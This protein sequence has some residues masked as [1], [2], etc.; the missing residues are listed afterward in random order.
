MN[1]STNVLPPFLKANDKL[2]LF[3]GVC[4][5]CNAWSR[6]II[7]FDTDRVFILASVQSPE[8]QKIL[9]HFA[10]PTSRF[11]TMLYVEGTHY[12]DKSDAFLKII[13]QLKFPWKFL[14]IFHWIPKAIRDWMYDRIALNRYA[15]FDRYDRCMLPTEDHQ[16]RFL[17][18]D[19]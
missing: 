1:A 17:K 8:G 12:F 10:M 15:F 14:A 5:L 19:K 13:R 6:F 2:I 9:T 7:Y 4:K 11:D 16:N 3:D 18:S